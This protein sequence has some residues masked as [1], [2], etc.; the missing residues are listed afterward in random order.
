[1]ANKS[2]KIVDKKCPLCN[3]ITESSLGYMIDSM[4]SKVPFNKESCHK[5]GLVNWNPIEKEEL[6]E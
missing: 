6:K 1:M 2:L 5:C 4:Y 3:N